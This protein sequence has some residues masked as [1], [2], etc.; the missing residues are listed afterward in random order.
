MATFVFLHGSFHAAWNWHRL[1]PVLTR[2]GHHG[3]ALDL[4]GHG[5]DATPS[6]RVSLD[7]CVN[8]VLNCI[9]AQPGPVVLVAHSRNGIVI[10][11]AAER[12]PG[13]IL[14]LV[15]LAAYL[16]PDG[17]SMMDYAMRD[18]ASLVV[19]NLEM[20]LDRKYIPLLV[21]L[22]R[23]EWL[24]RLCARMLPRALQV[25]RLKRAAYREALYHD[26]PPEITELAN[27]LLEAEPNWPGFSRLRL[28][29]G[30][31]GDRVSRRSAAN[32]D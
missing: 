25:H 7:A 5:R 9:D 12:R 23:H 13:K 8:A 21:R 24:Q 15:Y 11:Q 29:A 20:A 10:S 27:T 19:Q 14:G 26:C 31:Y 4:P 16:V 30:R 3:I 17:K 22:F 32:T 2:A 18:E 28:S 6:S 1:I